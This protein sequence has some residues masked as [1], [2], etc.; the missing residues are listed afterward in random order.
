MKKF[1]KIL[2]IYF[3]LAS[4]GYAQNFKI[5]K[6]LDLKDPWSLT[7]VNKEEILNKEKK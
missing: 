7:F 2:S 3:I 4:T 5:E 6:I 1:L